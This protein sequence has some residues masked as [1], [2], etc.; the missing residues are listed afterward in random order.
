MEMENPPAR[1][2]E[3]TKPC[4]DCG[5]LTYRFCRETPDALIYGLNR[6][7]HLILG[8]YCLSLIHI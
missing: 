5:E 8:Y 2:V 4:D 3:E 6:P 1:S 7:D